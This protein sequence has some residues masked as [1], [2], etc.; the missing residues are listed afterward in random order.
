[1]VN[2][3]V[4]WRLARLVLSGDLACD[5]LFGVMARQMC[6]LERSSSVARFIK[7]GVASIQG[8]LY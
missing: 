7:F 6:W 5:A 2:S 8:D 1:M 4:G 3:S